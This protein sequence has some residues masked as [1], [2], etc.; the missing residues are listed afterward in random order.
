MLVYPPGADRPLRADLLARAVLRSDLSPIPVTLEVEVRDAPETAGLQEGSIIRAGRDR[1]EF[2]LI[3][4][5]GYVEDGH[6]QAGRNIGTRTYIGVLARC[7]AIARPLTRAVI[8][9]GKTLGSAYRACGA[10]AAVIKDIQIPEF[11]CM[12]GLTPSFE[13]ARILGEH[14]ATL[15][16]QPS[17]DVAIER[18]EDLMQREPVVRMREDSSEHVRSGLL[19]QHLLPF[20]FTTDRDGAFIVGTNRAGSGVMYRPGATANILNAVLSA[21]IVR[22]RVPSSFAPHIN[23]GDCVQIGPQRYFVVTAAHA[24]ETSATGGDAAQTSTLWCAQV[25]GSRA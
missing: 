17:A 15:V 2:E 18:I 4:R 16:V 10:S 5:G 23:A 7:A 11:V 21:P 13:F 12:R 8:Q 19:E 9:Y 24:M 3:K 14:A 22:R 1:F 6:T 25:S 20:A